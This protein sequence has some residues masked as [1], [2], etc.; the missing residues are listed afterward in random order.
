MNKISV[1]K[2]ISELERLKDKTTLTNEDKERL[3]WLKL[4]FK[5]ELIKIRDK[6]NKS[7]NNIFNSLFRMNS[8]FKMTNT[9]RANEQ[10]IIS[11]LF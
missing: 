11:E 6:N 2:R 1:I 9:K 4:K 7:F 8:H 3:E 10:D 5:D